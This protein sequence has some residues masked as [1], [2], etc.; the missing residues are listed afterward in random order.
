MSPLTADG[1]RSIIQTGGIKSYT[2]EDLF[3]DYMLILKKRVDVDLTPKVYRKYEKSYK[4][5][6][7]TN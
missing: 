4:I 2:I 6:R 3:N 5:Y 1:L 7:R